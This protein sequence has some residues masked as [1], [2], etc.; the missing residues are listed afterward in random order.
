M[1]ALFVLWICLT[2]RRGATA[3]LGS[4]FAMGRYAVI[5]LQPTSSSTSESADSWST[6]APRNSVCWKVLLSSVSIL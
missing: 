5:K 3:S 6:H 4:I 1:T 2:K